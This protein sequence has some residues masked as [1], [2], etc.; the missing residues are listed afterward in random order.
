MTAR[1]RIETRRRSRGSP[2]RTWSSQRGSRRRKKR[3]GRAVP[4]VPLDSAS[5][6]KEQSG[7]TGARDD[8]GG[9]GEEVAGYVDSQHRHRIRDRVPN[10][11]NQQ[12]DCPKRQDESVRWVGRSGIE[13]AST[14]DGNCRPADVSCGGGGR[15]RRRSHLI[16]FGPQPEYFR[17][18]L[19]RSASYTAGAFGPSWQAR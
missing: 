17:T 12:R 11:E 14:P 8:E 16:T 10:P 15:G 6:K 13:Q 5:N 19:P 3:T 7:R 18:P 1:R 9:E 2:L 4:S